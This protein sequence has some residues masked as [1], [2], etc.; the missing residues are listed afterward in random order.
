MRDKITKHV[1]EFVGDYLRREGY[2]PNTEE[3]AAACGIEPAAVTR[4]LNV[5]ETKRYIQFQR[6]KPRSVR[7]LRE[8]VA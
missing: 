1:Y 4:H 3:I 5:L 6:G 8:R 2:P 7:L